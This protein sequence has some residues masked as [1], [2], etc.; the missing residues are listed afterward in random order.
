[1]QATDCQSGPA[2]LD[3]PGR[4]A[5]RRRCGGAQASRK[6]ARVAQYFTLQP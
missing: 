6:V 1:M 5:A 2:G 4:L 3:L